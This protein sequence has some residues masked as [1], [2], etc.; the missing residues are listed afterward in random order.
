[1]NELTK[2]IKEFITG[3][4]STFTILNDD[5]GVRYTYKVKKAKDVELFFVS[6]LAG[7]DN[8][9]DYN[10]MGIIN[11]AKNYMLT[12]KSRVKTESIVN[13]AFAWLWNLTKTDGHFPDSFHFYHEGR[14]GR[15]GRKLTTPSSVESGFGPI[16]INL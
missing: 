7:N 3:G 9:S 2:N 8:T 12:K 11:K 13:K 15:C 14:C 5:T 16:C 4:N 1:M 6:Y 10:Y